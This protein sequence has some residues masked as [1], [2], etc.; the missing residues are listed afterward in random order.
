[1]P[2]LQ[3]FK[4]HQ[5]DINVKTYRKNACSDG[6]IFIDGYIVETLVKDW[7]V[8]VDIL[9][10]DGDRGRYRLRGYSSVCS[11]YGQLGYG[12]ALAI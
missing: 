9:D 4:A 11:N 5:A 8:I 3:A 6:R 10:S 1:M 12:S 7:L 2:L